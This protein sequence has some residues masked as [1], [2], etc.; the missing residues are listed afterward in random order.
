MLYC[1]DRV[2]LKFTWY[3]PAILL[4]LMCCSNHYSSWSM[5]IN[6][7]FVDTLMTRSKNDLK[8]CFVEAIYT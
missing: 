8:G 7:S 3:F 2:A 1:K 6:K 5:D 4:V